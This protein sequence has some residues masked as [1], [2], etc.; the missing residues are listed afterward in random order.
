M[1]ATGVAFCL[2]K[3]WLADG[4]RGLGGIA[5]WQIGSSDLSFPTSSVENE[6]NQPGVHIQ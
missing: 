1:E 5:V 3:T 6:E 2:W 4:Y